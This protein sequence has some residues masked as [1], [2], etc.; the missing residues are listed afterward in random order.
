MRHLLTRLCNEEDGGG[1]MEYV[2]IAALIVIA[3][4]AAIKLFTGAIGAKFGVMGEQ[5]T[6]A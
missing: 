1:L 2:L 3:C 4:I 6:D 5:V